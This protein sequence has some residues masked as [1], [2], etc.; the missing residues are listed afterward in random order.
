MTPV[1]AGPAVTIRLA[2][3]V[4]DNSTGPSRYTLLDL[5]VVLVPVVVRRWS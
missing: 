4:L 5:S 3:A 1:A 2:L